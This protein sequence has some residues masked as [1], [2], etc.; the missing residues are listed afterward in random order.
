MPADIRA[1]I[2]TEFGEWRIRPFRSL[3]LILRT[4]LF[5]IWQETSVVQENRRACATLLLEKG[6]ASS[7]LAQTY[8]IDSL[9]SH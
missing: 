6:V 5:A 2:A 9:N 1:R 3:V 8:S 7:Q 4:A